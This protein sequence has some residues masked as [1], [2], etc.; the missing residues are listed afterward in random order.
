MLQSH[1]LSTV[2]TYVENSIW[3]EDPQL[4]TICSRNKEK[5]LRTCL[6]QYL[7][8]RCCQWF[9][10]VFPYILFSKNR[11][12]CLKCYLVMTAALAGIGH[13]GLEITIKSEVPVDS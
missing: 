9:F 6:Q 5:A 12:I 10:N 4:S 3:I 11:K 13:Y 1:Y 7:E 8:L 2:T